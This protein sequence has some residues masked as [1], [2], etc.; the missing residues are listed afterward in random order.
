MDNLTKIILGIIAVGSGLAL[1]ESI[2]T[3][4]RA[5][6]TG[7]AALRELKDLKELTG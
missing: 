5:L 2:V 6:S 3:T 7:S 1:I 4:K